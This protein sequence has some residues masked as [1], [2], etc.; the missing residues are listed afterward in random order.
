[1]S[2][3]RKKRRPGSLEDRFQADADTDPDIREGLLRKEPSIDFKP[4]VG[5]IPDGTLNWNPDDLHTRV[6]WL[7]KVVVFRRG[8]GVVT[9][10]SPT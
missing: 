8:H 6:R 9:G 1:M 3:R 7:R 4:A 2:E 10:G 5:V